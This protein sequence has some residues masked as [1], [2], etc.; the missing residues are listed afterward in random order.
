MTKGSPDQ[1]G[2]LIWLALGVLL[3]LGSVKLGLGTPHSPA[4][5]FGPF[6]TGCLL[7]LFGLILA[8]NSIL[9]RSDE[10]ESFPETRPRKGWTKGFLS[11]LVLFLYAS[12]VNTLGF[13]IS[14]SLLMFFL[15][16]VLEPRKWLTLVAI[17]VSASLLSYLLFGLWLRVSLPKGIFGIG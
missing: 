17:S 10:K 7:G 6:L 16:K 1:I 13:I 4:S 3:C 11:L 8:F 9:R 14:T 5:G 2:G 15:F 12:L